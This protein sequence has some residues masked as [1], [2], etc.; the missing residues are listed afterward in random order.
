MKETHIKKITDFLAQ[1]QSTGLSPEKQADEAY[2]YAISLLCY[3]IWAFANEND[4]FRGTFAEYPRQ[5][6]HH[7]QAL[8]LLDLAKARLAQS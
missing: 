1:A 8:D 7:K 4:F 2:D 5:H 6:I 3:D